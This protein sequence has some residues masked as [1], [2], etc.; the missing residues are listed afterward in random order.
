MSDLPEDL[1]R[2]DALLGRTERLYG[3]PA[4]VLAQTH[5]TNDDAKAG[6]R[7]GAPS[8]SV[9]IA[10]AQHAGRGRQGRAW[11]SRAGEALLCSVL[12]RVSVAPQDLPRMTIACGLAVCD[13]ASAVTGRADIQLKWPN[14]VVCDGRKIAGILAESTIRGGQVD[15][16]V[17]GIGLNVFTR[18][19]PADIADVATSLAL[20]RTAEAAAPLCR[21]KLLVA[22]L[23]ALAR[24]VPLA[25]ARGLGPFQA[26]L[27]QL[28]ALRGKAVHRAPAAGDAELTATG[29]TTTGI[30]TT[31]ITTS[32]IAA[33]IDGDGRLLVRTTAGLIERW[34]SGE[35]HLLRA[36]ESIHR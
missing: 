14:D 31:G 36:N 9:W 13:V 17:V 18:E 22:V 20:L 2:I 12:I 30:T 6:A 26:K 11:L 1:Q 8:G 28:D 27:E 5:S 35:V 33:G 29:S 25:L 24:Y 21:A 23:D 32:G 10:D 4:V 34:D 15:A 16:V 19:F 3:G 7:A